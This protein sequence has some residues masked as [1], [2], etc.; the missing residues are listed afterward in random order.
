MRIKV[1]IY[2]EAQAFGFS[3]FDVGK[4]EM[5]IKSTEEKVNVNYEIEVA[6]GYGF[7]DPCS[8]YNAAKNQIRKYKQGGDFRKKPHAPK[9]VLG[10]ATLKR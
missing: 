2:R 7:T 8:A 1:H 4:D 6:Y 3:V 9:P 10:G 5:L